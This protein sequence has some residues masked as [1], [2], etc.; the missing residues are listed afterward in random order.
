[1]G[2]LLERLGDRTPHSRSVLAADELVPVA[3]CRA[4]ADA[5]DEQ[6]VDLPPLA[7]AVSVDAVEG[8]VADQET[9]HVAFRYA[10][11]AVTVHADGT[12]AVYEAS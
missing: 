1:M 5:T 9:G 7:N 3:V 8:V 12:I 6:P 11:M 2:M 10:G 4:V